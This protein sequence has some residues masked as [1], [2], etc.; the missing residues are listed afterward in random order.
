[1]KLQLVEV[2]L[3]LLTV[4]TSFLFIVDSNVTFVA[5]AA[6][7]TDVFNLKEIVP[8]A[9]VRLVGLIILT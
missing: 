5:V 4:T 8:G 9:T 7:F 6:K 3:K 2:A 1:M